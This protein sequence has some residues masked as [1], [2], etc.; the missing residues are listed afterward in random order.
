MAEY[1]GSALY[2]SWVTAA[3]TAVPSPDFRTFTTSETVD[4]IDTTAGSDARKSYIT[5][6]IDGEASLNYVEQSLGTANWQK[7]VPGAEGTLTWG[8]EGTATGKPKWV[9]PARVLTRDRAI[10][11]DGVV[12]IDIGF[13]LSGTLSETLY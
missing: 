11:Y 7:F 2:L 6:P 8:P 1:S 4:E 13:R 9:S 12:A 5:G 10:P 3:G